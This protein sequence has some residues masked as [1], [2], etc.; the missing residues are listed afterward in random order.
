[1]PELTVEAMRQIA[2]LTG[3]RWADAELEGIRPALQRALEMLERLDEQGLEAVEPAP[4]YR[5][6]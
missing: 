1:M 6:R 2:A 3:F 5:L 4:Q